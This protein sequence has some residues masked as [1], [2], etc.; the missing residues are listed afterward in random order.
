MT[1]TP[2]LAM[3]A[4]ENSPVVWVVGLVVEQHNQV[5]MLLRRPDDFLPNLWEIPGG[6]VDPGESLH[7]ALAREL[8]EETGLHLSQVV[9][10]VNQY[11]Y[12]G[13]FGL[14]RQWNFAVKT[15]GGAITHPEHVAYQWASFHLASLLPMSDEM[16]QTL[17][18]FWTAGNSLH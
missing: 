7:E 5:L 12:A 1:L 11:D 4:E 13:E 3:R 2:L 16:R 17:K 6:H 14:T 8:C 18:L 15:T 10:Y 9:R